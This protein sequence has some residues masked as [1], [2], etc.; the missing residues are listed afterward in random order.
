MRVIALITLIFAA[1]AGAAAGADTQGAGREKSETFL[2]GDIA[3]IWQAMTPQMQRALGSEAGLTEFRSSLERDFGSE[4]DVVREEVQPGGDG[5]D[6]YRRTSKWSALDAPILMQWAFDASGKI[7]G[8]LVQPV[9]QLAES[10]FLDYQTKAELH[11]PFDGR[12][13]V[14]WGGRTL[15]QNYHAADRAQR[16]AMD[17]LIYRSGITHTGDTSNLENYYCWDQPILA[18]AGGTIV[19]VTSDLPDNPIGQTDTQHPVGN[20]V[21]IDLGTGEFAFLAHMRQGSIV[22]AEGDK[23][24]VGD[25]LGR[26]GNSGNTS[27]PHLH[28]HLQTTPDLADGEGLPAQF[29]DYTADD[30]PVERDE[31]MA[32]QQVASQ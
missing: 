19:A 26:C 4:V 16:F 14:V 8:F 12:W 1:M 17:L 24:A 23:V 18:P 28:M 2:R 32:G 11:L 30:F 6:L 5:T 15:Q 25:E 29:V 13:F 21:V 31:L 3:A 7:A 20:H 9:P 22:V 27:E 10:R